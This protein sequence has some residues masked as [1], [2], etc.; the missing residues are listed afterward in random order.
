MFARLVTGSMTPTVAPEEIQRIVSH[1]HQDPFEV[2]GS[3]RIE[4][5]GKTRWVVRAYFPKADAVWVVRPEER[6]E[7]PMQSVGHP[8]FFECELDV[9][10]LRNY[11]LRVREGDRDR[12]I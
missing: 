2:L 10:E 1:Q 4:R 6:A 5:D 12:V 3:H 11:Q 7:Y 9:P 8:H